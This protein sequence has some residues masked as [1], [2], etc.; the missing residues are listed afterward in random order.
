[1]PITRSSHVLQMIVFHSFWQM[2]SIPLCIWT[3]PFFSFFSFLD[4]TFFIH[5]SVDGHLGCFH[6]LATVK[7]VSVHI[8]MCTSFELELFSEYM[9]RSG[10]SGS[11]GNYIFSF[12]RNLHTVLH[13]GCTNVHSHQQCRRFPFFPH[14]LKLLLL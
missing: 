9:P 12:I 13:S 5:S 6:V 14:P 7:S 8:E 10:I 11:Y 2:C 4:H 1:M 3:T